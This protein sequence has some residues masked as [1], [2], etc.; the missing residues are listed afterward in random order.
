M[1]IRDEGASYE[2][3]FWLFFFLNYESMTTHLQEIWKIHNK[4]TLF[5][6]FICI[7]I[8]YYNYFLSR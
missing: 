8:T 7:K 5:C 3:F 4:A 1:F 2:S 6:I